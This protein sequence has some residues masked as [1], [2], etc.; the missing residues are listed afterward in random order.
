[1]DLFERSPL[2]RHC[3]LRVKSLMPLK[4]EATRDL[5][6]KPSTDNES[7]YRRRPPKL[8][9]EEVAKRLTAAVD[10]H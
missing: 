10:S 6:T 7:P 9:S 4:P 1:M 2:A 5:L 8:H 3:D